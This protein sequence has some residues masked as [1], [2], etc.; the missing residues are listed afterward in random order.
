MFARRLGSLLL[1]VGGLLEAARLLVFGLVSVSLPE[2]VS[3]WVYV[4]PATCIGAGLIAIGVSIR[5]RGRV[6]LMI[7]GVLNL[8]TVVVNIVQIATGSPLGPGPSQLAFLVS[9]AAVV[10]AA[11][12]LLSNPS[13]HGP[14]RWAIAIPAAGIV[15]FFVGVYVPP[16]GLA[17]LDL[18][19]GIGFAIAGVLL[20]RRTRPRSAPAW[21]GDS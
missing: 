21:P 12:L 14:A 17:R 1:L 7:A 15:L 8:A 13:P 16:L 20:V 6:P 3:T 2:P 10:V 9:L 11:A 18:L 19:P 4:V 5:G